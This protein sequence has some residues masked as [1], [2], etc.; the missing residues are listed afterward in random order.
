MKVFRFGERKMF[1]FAEVQGKLFGVWR[2]GGLEFGGLEF[3]E[4]GKLFA[5]ES[6][7]EFGGLEV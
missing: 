6:C 3:G 4:L 5:T 1:V 7:L 2:F